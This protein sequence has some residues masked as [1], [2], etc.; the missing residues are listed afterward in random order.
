MPN[1]L[2]VMLSSPNAAAKS[3]ANTQERPDSQA[4][5]SFQTVMEQEAKQP[6]ELL[7]QSAVQVPEPEAE[8][9]LTEEGGVAEIAVASEDSLLPEVPVLATPAQNETVEKRV[10]PA[11]VA[12]QPPQKAQADVEQSHKRPAEAPAGQAN[13]PQPTVHSAF[14]ILG[15]GH[16]HPRAMQSAA[17]QPKDGSAVSISP[18]TRPQG[19]P[20]LGTSFDPD[21]D[22]LRIQ[23]SAGVTPKQPTAQDRAPTFVQMQLL[24]TEKTASQTDASSLREVEDVQPMRDS[25]LFSPT[26]DA[27]PTVQAM[28]ATAR[29]EVARAIAGQM[30]TSITARPHSGV[31]EIA[32]NPEELGRVSIVLNGRDDGL[33]L[34]IAAER[35]ETLEMMRRHLSVLE[36]EFRNLGLGDLSFDLG[37]SSDARQDGSPGEDSTA[38]STPPPENRAEDGPTPARMGAD[39]RIDI[40][41]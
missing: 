22:S 34:A 35:P 12:T 17:P 27:G 10:E 29:A 6:S 26:R 13:Q 8:A 36:A 25:Q 3:E 4:A 14:Q 18:E 28:T 24:A 19:V 9:D 31:I 30:A 16:A 21:R 11:L 33:H 23:T 37:T 1:P 32:L 20:D 40:R 41:M 15:Q 7:E 38:F 2:S 39:G 5:A